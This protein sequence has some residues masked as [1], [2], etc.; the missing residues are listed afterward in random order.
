MAVSQAGPPMSGLLPRSCG[1]EGQGQQ[2]QQRTGFGVGGH[3]GEGPAQARGQPQRGGQDDGQPD[4]G[5]QGGRGQADGDG[6]QGEQDREDD[7]RG[8]AVVV[9]RAGGVSVDPGEPGRGAVGAV[10]EHVAY[11]AGSAGRGQQRER[12]QAA[13]E[14]EPDGLGRAAADDAFG[15]GGCVGVAFGGPEQ[16][17]EDRVE[18]D[19][20]RRAVDRAGGSGQDAA[21]A[22]AE[23]PDGQDPADQPARGGGSRGGP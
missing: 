13:P 11:A 23:P 15:H 20:S 14:H 8:Q 7:G 16:D 9:Q 4:G 10:G 1:P 12:G 2:G 19:R 22:L 17:G 6:H 21:E 18:D 5:A 3:A